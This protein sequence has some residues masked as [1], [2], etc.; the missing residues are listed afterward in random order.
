MIMDLCLVTTTFEEQGRKY[1]LHMAK[2]DDK[3]A[4]ETLYTKAVIS[5]GTTCWVADI[6][7]NVLSQMKNELQL[8]EVTCVVEF[9]QYSILKKNIQL[10]FERHSAKS[11]ILGKRFS[12]SVIRLP[13]RE[14]PFSR[15]RMLYS[16]A[17]SHERLMAQ[18]P[19]VST[20]R[21]HDEWN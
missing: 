12:S 10:E 15:G 6:T 4:L 2:H 18:A 7:E 3:P 21:P 8:A 20:L 5:D 1:V 14:C 11:L 17:R 9:L 19:F 13:L 16:M